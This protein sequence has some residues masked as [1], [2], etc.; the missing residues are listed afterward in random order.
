MR[1]AGRQTEE[2]DGFNLAKTLMTMNNTSF[3][4]LFCAEHKCRPYDFEMAVFRLCLYPS[5]YYL[6]CLL[7]M[8]NQDY[9]DEDF[10]LIEAVK[11][12][13]SVGEIKAEIDALRHTHPQKGLFRHWLKVRIS[14][15]RLL[16][17]ATRLFPLREKSHS[18]SG[19]WRELAKETP[20]QR[21][22]S[23][24]CGE[25]RLCDADEREILRVRT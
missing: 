21:D 9:F 12:L 22:V 24:A 25:S 13:T 7:M 16:N 19:V 23:D 6:G 3:C 18:A 1:A 20:R 5:R 10:A 8:V 11:N 14:G 4:G 15:P 2:A 17:E